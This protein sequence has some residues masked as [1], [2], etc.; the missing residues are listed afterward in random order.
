M[1]NFADGDVIFDA[2]QNARQKIFVAARGFFEHVG[3]WDFLTDTQWA[4]LFD[5]ARWRLDEATLEVGDGDVDP[6]A[7]QRIEVVASLE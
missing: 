3:L 6:M 7:A 4:P 2:I 1:R 5:E